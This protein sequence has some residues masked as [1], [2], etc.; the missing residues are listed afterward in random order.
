V[1]SNEESV[2]TKLQRIAEKACKEPGCKFTSLFHLMNTEL[3]RGCFMR[4]RKDAASGIDGVTKE[5]YGENLEANLTALVGRLHGMSYIPQPVR[6][7]YIPKPGSTKQR[8][9]GIPA[10]E[11]KLVQAGLVR[12]LEAVYEADF[13]DDSYGFRPGRGCHDA[14]RALSL[15]VE[16]GK[17]HYIVEA[18]IK[19][20][21]DNV[22]HEW[23]M[24]FLG[25]RIDDKRVLR[26]VKRFLIAGV[27]EDGKVSATEEGTPQGGN[28]S[29]VLANIYL[30]YCLDLWCTRTFKRTCEGQSRLIRYADDFVVCFQFES[31]AKRFRTELDGRLA[32]FGLEVAVEKTKIMEFGPLA[33]LKAKARDEKPQTF[34]FLGLTHFCSRTRNGRRFRM[35]R[36]TS[37]KKYKAK[38]LIFKEWLKKSRTLPTPAIMKTVAAKLRGHFAYYGVTDNSKGIGRFAYEVTRLLF[39]WLDR[40]GKRGSLSWE[41]FNRLLAKFPLPKPRIV[42]DLFATK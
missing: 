13:I 34:D 23:L 41:K 36:V 30:H 12:I 6:R 11:D 14:M 19:G 27:F 9:L 4:L 39:K 24:E 5:E 21:F 32:K 16:G 40:R 3:L 8:P 18:D 20:F 29:P 37:R 22:Q 2:E 42:V 7:V 25:H 15:E 26:Y 33:A 35:K 17:V 10:L 38:L 31:D 28:I 1:L